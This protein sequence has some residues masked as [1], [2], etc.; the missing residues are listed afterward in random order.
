MSCLSK[1]VIEVFPPVLTEFTKRNE[2]FISPG[3]TCPYC[4]GDGKV[5]GPQIN[6]YQYEPVNCP[7]CEG[8]GRLQAEIVIKWSTD[9][10]NS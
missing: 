3:H 10:K 4:N 7:V 8:A 6:V 1:P 2:T 9:K 5:C